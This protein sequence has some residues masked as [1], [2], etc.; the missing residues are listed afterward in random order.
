MYLLGAL[1]PILNRGAAPQLV[2]D[3]QKNPK[4]P[5]IALTMPDNIS[6]KSNFLGARPTALFQRPL[7]QVRDSEVNKHHALVVGSDNTN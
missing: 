1:P 6:L 2:V 3:D 7:S 4:P 5:V